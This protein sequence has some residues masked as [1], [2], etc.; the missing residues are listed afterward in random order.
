MAHPST[1]GHF[2][3]FLF[4]GTQLTKLALAQKGAE[5]RSQRCF[6]GSYVSDAQIC[7]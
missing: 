7:N 2:G 5:L 1:S 3:K 6:K 4:L